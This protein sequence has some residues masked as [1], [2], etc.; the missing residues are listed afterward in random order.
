VAIAIKA[1]TSIAANT[2]IVNTD[3]AQ[4]YAA[5][6][7]SVVKNAGTGNYQIQYCTY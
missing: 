1:E 7:V 3:V 4:I 6:V 5:V 2:T